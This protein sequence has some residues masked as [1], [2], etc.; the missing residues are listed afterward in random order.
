VDPEKL[1]FAETHEWTHIDDGA[2]GKVA[3]V[4]ISAFAVEQLTDIVYLELPAV[5]AEFNSGDEVGQI[6][7]VKAVSPLYAP[8]NGKVI[9]V[10]ESLPESLDSLSADPYG[11]A[12]IYKLS[13]SDESALASLM[14]YP[15]YQRQCGEAS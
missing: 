5:G 13:V 14:N 15:A 11:Q 2:G 1:L 9:E 12:W 6:E 8:V 10:N 7:S 3:T 4:G